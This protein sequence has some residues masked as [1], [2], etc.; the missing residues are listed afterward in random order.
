MKKFL[1][2][3]ILSVAAFTTTYADAYNCIM[4]THGDEKVAYLFD[5]KPTIKYQQIDG[6]KNA[7][8]FV[9]G[10]A[11]P[12]VSVPLQN[13]AKLSA[14]YVQSNSGYP[15][16]LDNVAIGKPSVGGGKFFEK[17]NV[18]IIKNGKKYNVAGQ[19]IK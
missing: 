14:F 5:K 4:V 16:G 12:V 13:G 6:V 2:S 11:S 1:L 19:E 17:G 8:I 10:E 9:D 15:T 3:F 18:I 7:C